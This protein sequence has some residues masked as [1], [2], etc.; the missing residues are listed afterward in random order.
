ME[1]FQN[2]QLSFK[3]PKALDELKPCQSNW[4]CD[5][6]RKMVYDFRGMEEA[7]I[8]ETF[9]KSGEQ[10]CGIYDTNKLKPVPSTTF[11]PKWVFVFGITALSELGCNQIPANTIG[12]VRMT[13]PKDTIHKFQTVGKILPLYTYPKFNG[14]DDVFLKY[15]YRNVKHYP[16]YQGRIFVQFIVNKDGVPTNVKI[17]KGGYD[18][19]NKQI[20]DLIKHSPRWKPPIMNRK[21]LAV[22]YTIALN[23]H[24]EQ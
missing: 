24:S 16:E 20:T 22:P 17:L 7:Q 2:I 21:P 5:G 19:L 15:I 9:T 8:V 4:Y 23:F 12:K 3:C 6:C 13:L 1:A 11:I 10:L 18:Q 14:G